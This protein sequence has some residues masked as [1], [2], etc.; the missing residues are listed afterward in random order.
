VKSPAFL[1]FLRALEFELRLEDAQDVCL[2][3]QG[4]TVAC[5]LLPFREVVFADDET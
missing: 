1:A 4:A 3:Q 2:N 5:V